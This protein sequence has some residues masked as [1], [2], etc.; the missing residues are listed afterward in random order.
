MAELVYNGKVQ[1]KRTKASE[2]RFHWI[3]DRECHK[4]FR[5]YWQP[6]KLNY[7]DYWTKHHAA[8]H[9]QNVRKEC[10]MPHIVLEILRV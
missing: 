4:Q 8:Q 3:R 6:G 5:I 9:H 2:I 7:A 10:L 1:S